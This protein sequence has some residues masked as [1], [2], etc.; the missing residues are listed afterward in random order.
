MRMTAIQ[1]QTVQKRQDMTALS[2]ALKNATAGQGSCGFAARSSQFQPS[3]RPSTPQVAKRLS[4]VQSQIIMA[5]DGRPLGQCR[6]TLA[7]LISLW[8]ETDEDR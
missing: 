4:S 5:S 6:A 7:S 3:A 1:N 2:T 8:L